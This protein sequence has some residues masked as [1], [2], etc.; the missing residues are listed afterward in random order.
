MVCRAQAHGKGLM[1][2]FWLTNKLC[3][4]PFDGEQL[5]S[6]IVHSHGRKKGHTPFSA[7]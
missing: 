5:P 7:V 3:C 2:K 4:V 1:A 6:A